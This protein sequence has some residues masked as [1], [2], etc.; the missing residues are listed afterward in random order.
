MGDEPRLIVLL[1]RRLDVDR[2]EGSL[3]DLEDLRSGT[4]TTGIPPLFQTSRRA[5]PLATELV[6]MVDT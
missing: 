3:L 6:V 1:E 2:S 4:T 5:F